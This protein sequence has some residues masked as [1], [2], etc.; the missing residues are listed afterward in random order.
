MLTFSLCYGLPGKHGFLQFIHEH[1]YKALTDLQDW[2]DFFLFSAPCI[3]YYHIA[4]YILLHLSFFPAFVSISLNE[5]WNSVLL[6]FIFLAQF[7][8]R[9]GRQ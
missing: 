6:H 8:T 5:G 7:L 1:F 3:E 9:I 4:Y 2:V